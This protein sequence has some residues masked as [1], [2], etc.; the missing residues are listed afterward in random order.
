MHFHHV[1]YLVKVKGVLLVRQLCS[2]MRCFTDRIEFL[3]VLPFFVI[4]HFPWLVKILRYIFSF[5]EA[6]KALS[7]LRNVAFRLIKARRETSETEMV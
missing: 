2:C 7:N 5:T 3:S 4:G 6:G 1:E